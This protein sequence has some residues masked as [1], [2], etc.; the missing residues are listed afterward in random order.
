MEHA[1]GRAITIQAGLYGGL[2]GHGTEDSLKVG[3][4]DPEVTKVGEGTV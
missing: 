1:R 4:P 3:H 2:V